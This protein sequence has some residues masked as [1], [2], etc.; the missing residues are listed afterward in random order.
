MEGYIQPTGGARYAA[1][2]VVAPFAVTDATAIARRTVVDRGL[3][4]NCHGELAGHGGGRRNVQYCLMCHGPTEV[5]NDRASRFEIGEVLVPSVDLKVMVH[6]IHMGEELSQAYVLFGNPT[7]STTNPAGTPIDFADTRYPSRRNNC[8]SCHTGTTYQLP[9]PLTRVESHDEIRTCTDDPLADTDN[10]CT[11]TGFVVQ[12]TM[13]MQPEAAACVGCH[14]S[15]STVAHTI[16]MTT[17]GG[18]ES[19]ATCHGPGSELDVVVV[20]GLE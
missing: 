10:L 1:V 5:N 7:P 20:H 2:S 9:L 14:D 4:N 6:R 8:A 17:L 19:C 18:L 11:T 12:Q 15:S 13:T 3:C 16:V